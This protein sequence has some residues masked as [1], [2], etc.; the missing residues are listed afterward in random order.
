LVAAGGIESVVGHSPDDRFEI[1]SM[2]RT[3]DGYKLDRTHEI[4]ALVLL[5]VE[6]APWRNAVVSHVVDDVKSGKLSDAAAV[7]DALQLHA[8]ASHPSTVPADRSSPEGALF[9]LWDAVER[10]DEALIVDSFYFLR[11]GDGGAARRHLAGR[12]VADHALAKALLAKFGAEQGRRLIQ[13]CGLTYAHGSLDMHRR[14]RW[15]VEDDVARAVMP[16][17]RYDVAVR[18][19]RASGAWRIEWVAENIG[20][21]P[22][23]TDDDKERDRW[24]QSRPQREMDVLKH[25]DRYPS[26]RSI[27]TALSENYARQKQPDQEISAK[28]MDRRIAEARRQIA[29]HPATSTR[30]AFEYE[31]GISML[32]FSAAALRGDAKSA[33]KYYFADGDDGAY[34]LARVRRRL[35]IDELYE[36]VGKEIGGDAFQA[37]YGLTDVADDLYGLAM[38]NWEV[39]GDRARGW[40][41]EQH[42]GTV[43]EASL[44]KQ[45]GMWKIDVSDETNGDPKSAATRAQEETRKLQQLTEDV[46]RLNFKNAEEFKKALQESGVKGAGRPQ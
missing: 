2:A 17:G 31:F 26:P 12:L 16:Y 5:N 44:R 32:Q 33:S 19:V 28:E 6:D 9:V 29:T 40:L 45:D 20:W 22:D 7:S 35:A 4:A 23:K 24:E 42:D 30:Q 1:V 43:P 14:A 34:A 38:L 3:N 21:Q 13:E 15:V 46:K 36:A 11:E 8:P 27:L 39:Q 37:R 25:L 18:M 10:G 41:N